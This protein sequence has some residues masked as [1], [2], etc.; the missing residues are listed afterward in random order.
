LR[1]QQ[2]G[3]SRRAPSASLLLPFVLA[4][5]GETSTLDL[6]AV[7]DDGRPDPGL[8]ITVLP[9]DPNA[10]Y[11]SLARTAATPRPEFP[12]LEAAMAGFRAH[13]PTVR[14]GAGGWEATRDSVEALADSLQQ[15]D[16]TTPSYR[17]AYGRLR[18]LYERL[19]QRA[20]ERDRAVRGAYRADRELADRAASAAD[21]LRRWEGAAYV[22]YPDVLAAAIAA[23]GRGAVRV[24]PDSTGLARITLP[25][26]RWWL[27][28][29]RRVPDNPF[30]ERL[31]NLVVTTNR[32]VPV[33]VRITAGNAGLQ[34]RH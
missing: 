4:A 21:E 1:Q 14:P 27:R 13:T 29:R 18:A 19:G 31:W 24:T 34:W 20:A 7:R 3:H 22:A 33:R 2:P 16:R 5:C 28:A 25:P 9:V 30:H 12:D 6:I 8:S 17:V 10:L 26:G 32:L 15:T 23:S 11:D